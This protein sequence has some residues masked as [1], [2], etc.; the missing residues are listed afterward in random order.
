[1]DNYGSLYYSSVIVE[2][3]AWLTSRVGGVF[4]VSSLA[5]LFDLGMILSLTFLSTL[6]DIADWLCLAFPFEII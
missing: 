6:N 2:V 1:M 5:L 4:S 3:D